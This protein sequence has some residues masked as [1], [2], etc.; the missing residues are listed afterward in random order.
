[1]LC[2]CA[3]LRKAARTVTQVFDEAVQPVGL[4]ATQVTLLVAV[5]ARGP[6]PISALAE[7]LV[8]DRTTLTRNLNPLERDGLLKIASGED[9]RTRL[10][11]ITAKVKPLWKK[12]YP[13]EQA[14]SKMIQELGRD[15][16]QTLIRLLNETVSIAQKR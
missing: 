7:I 14:Q 3:N 1:M 2:T 12:R 9:Q 11:Q 16:W 15:S 4:R 10:I 5:A 8:T 13:V 6:I